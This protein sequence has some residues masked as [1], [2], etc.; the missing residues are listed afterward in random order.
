[1][2]IAI[3]FDSCIAHYDSWKGID[4]F[5]PPIKG[6]SEAIT[7]MKNAGHRIIIHTVRMPSLAL[8]NYLFINNIYFDAINENPWTYLEDPDP[9]IKRKIAADVYIDDK[10]LTFKGNWQQTLKETLEF[11]NWEG[12]NDLIDKEDKQ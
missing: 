11:K 10:G 5:G 7:D 12:H 1:M 8:Q 2:I 3:D 6:A 4:V 9:T